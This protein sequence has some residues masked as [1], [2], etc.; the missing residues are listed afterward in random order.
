MSNTTRLPLPLAAG[1]AV[2]LAA[3]TAWSSPGGV[4]VNAVESGADADSDP[5]DLMPRSAYAGVAPTPVPITP[6]PASIANRVTPVESS[7]ATT[8]S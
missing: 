1:R 8:R 5:G 7:S 6:T 3:L 4:A 2:S